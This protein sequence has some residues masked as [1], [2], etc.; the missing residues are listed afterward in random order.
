MIV[1]LIRKEVD[2]ESGKILYDLPF[3]REVLEKYWK[4]YTGEWYL[5]GEWL[6][7]KNPG[8]FPG[9]II[10]RLDYPGNVIVE[11]EARTVLP[12]T[13][14]INFMW[15]GS[16]DEEKNQ[17]G[18]SY[19]AGI[20]GWWNGKVGIE[21]SPEYKL[22]AC[23]P[24]FNFEP[25]RIYRI[26]GGSINGHCFICADGRL[27]LEVT[28]PDPIDNQKYAKVGFEAYCSHIQIRNLKI[29]EARWRE[30]DEIYIPEFCSRCW[31]TLVT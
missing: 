16:W 11:F 28:D 2:T 20:Q 31:I 4:I 14:D 19:V 3:T 1:R 15:N 13:H 6:T 12:C 5:D 26:L 7:G 22:T 21:K 23:T 27:L 10:S 8:N 17:R 24:L 18:Y 30:I 9:M 29:R 25:G